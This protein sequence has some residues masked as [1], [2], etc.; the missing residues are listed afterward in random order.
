ML[1]RSGQCPLVYTS[2]LL[3]L[4]SPP[5]NHPIVVLEGF[6]PGLDVGGGV[7]EGLLVFNSETVANHGAANL[8][9]EL[10]AGVG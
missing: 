9:D 8:G 4:S 2:P 7:F 10:L 5:D 3:P 6:E 1:H